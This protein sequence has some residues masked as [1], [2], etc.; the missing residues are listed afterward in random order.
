MKQHPT[1]A[2]RGF[3][4]IELLI[5]IVIII[6]LSLLVMALFSTATRAARDTQRSSDIHTIRTGFKRYRA[7]STKSDWFVWPGGAPNQ[8]GRCW[9]FVDDGGAGCPEAYAFF[10]S[11]LPKL[12][13]YK[14]ITQFYY[15]TDYPSMP[16]GIRNI[17][18]RGVDKDK[19]F[20]NTS[21]V[22]VSDSQI[23]VSNNVEDA[24]LTYFV[25]DAGLNG[26]PRC[27]A[28]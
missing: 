12:T 3:T 22:C 14:S 6:I 11:I 18:D 21:T 5:V 24:V 8:S 10:Q 25:E 15:A 27:V 16:Y 1:R 13:Y 2:T 26:S 23:N 9:K 4:I 19:V 20:I 28:L 17:V 7:E